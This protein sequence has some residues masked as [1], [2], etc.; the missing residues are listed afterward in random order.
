LGQKIGLIWKLDFEN[1]FNYLKDSGFV[2]FK[3]ESVHL[4]A[5]IGDIG[6]DYLPGH[7]HA[8][9]LSFELAIK[10]KRVIVNSGTSE[11]GLSQERLRQRSTSA[12]STI[13]LDGK[14][15]SEVWSGFRVA[16]RARVSLIQL[17]N[18][19]EIMKISAEHDGYKRYNQENIHTR[20]WIL[21]HDQL[22]ISDQVLGNNNDVILRFYLHP[23]I[24]IEKYRNALIL[25][26]VKGPLANV[27]SNLSMEVVK[28]SYH[29]K[30]GSKQVNSCILIK[31][32]TPFSSIVS[33]EFLSQ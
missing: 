22:D 28:S 14:S 13:E 19:D 9:S 29:D 31:G 12:H 16:R 11:Y 2:V 15:S 30:F 10:G 20:S 32:K 8:D 21:T 27:V 23:D 24:E 26:T 4:I 5:D 7:A 18:K 17:L 1:Q 3:N 6:P 33:I 25:S